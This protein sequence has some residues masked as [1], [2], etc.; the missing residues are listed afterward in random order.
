MQVS[1]PCL[2]SVCRIKVRASPIN[3]LALHAATSCASMIAAAAAATAAHPVCVAL[4][5]G[6]CVAAQ[7]GQADG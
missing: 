7:A 3:T 2:L 4:L 6:V 5:L 1:G